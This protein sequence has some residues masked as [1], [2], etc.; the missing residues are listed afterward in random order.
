MDHLALQS[1]ANGSPYDPMAI[2]PMAPMT[3][4]IAIGANGDLHW[5]HPLAPMRSP[6]DQMD[7]L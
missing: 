2:W 7:P 6:L 4:V 1:G 3:I 5:R